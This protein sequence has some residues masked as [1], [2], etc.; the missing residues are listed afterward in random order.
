LL[1]QPPSQP[2]R[3]AICPIMDEGSVGFMHTGASEWRAPS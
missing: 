1:T 3:M 2:T